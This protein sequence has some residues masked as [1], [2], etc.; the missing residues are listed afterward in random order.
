MKQK[1]NIMKT[2]PQISEEE[3]ESYMDFD[4]V[5]AKHKQQMSSGSKWFR[6]FAIGFISATVTI[7]I[8]FYSMSGGNEVP[9]SESISIDTVINSTTDSAESI[10]TSKDELNNDEAQT[11]KTDDKKSNKARVSSEKI[12]KSNDKKGAEPQPIYVEAQPIEGFPALYEYFN[13]ELRYPEVAVKDSIAGVVTVFFIINKE[14]LPVQLS[15][16]N[17]LGEAFDQEV[18]RLIHN[19]PKWKSATLNGNPVQSRISI[20]LTFQILK[21]KKPNQ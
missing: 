1:L 16:E 20:P 18:L 8:Y 19:M 5:V 17:S 14:G 3:I 7:A 21:S 12:E 4:A 10:T 2:R 11:L 15:I 6:Y 13:K 9:V